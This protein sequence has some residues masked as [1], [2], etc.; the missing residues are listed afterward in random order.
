M[1]EQMRRNGDGRLWTRV[2]AAGPETVFAVVTLVVQSMFMVVG[3][4]GE[5][6]PHPLDVAPPWIRDAISPASRAT[7]ARSAVLTRL[8]LWPSA[9]WVSPTPR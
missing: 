4:P 6:L 7:A 2:L 3:L 1:R 9:N 5:Y 8:P